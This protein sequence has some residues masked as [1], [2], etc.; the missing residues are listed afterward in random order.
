M[1]LGPHLCSCRT[2]FLALQFEL[3]QRTP[4][5]PSFVRYLVPLLRGCPVT[6]PAGSSF[7]RWWWSKKC[8]SQHLAS[9]SWSVVYNWSAEPLC[10]YRCSH[11]NLLVVLLDKSQG[12]KLFM[13]ARGNKRSG[14]S[15]A[16]CMSNRTLLLAP[17]ESTRVA[18]PALCILARGRQV[19]F[20]QCKSSF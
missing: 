15:L 8:S 4:L 6:S 3:Q 19:C 11:L 13:V 20:M 7:G 14:I 18:I 1:R 9:C 12:N 10:L 17:T 2:G 5:Q 16:H